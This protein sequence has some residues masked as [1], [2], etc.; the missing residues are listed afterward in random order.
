MC[1]WLSLLNDSIGLGMRGRKRRTHPD[2]VVR[3]CPPPGP[4]A[5]QASPAAS[6]AAGAAYTLSP[7]LIKNK[8]FML[9]STYTAPPFLLRYIL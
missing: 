7:P 9:P 6:H 2:R 5:S 1:T 8:N 3:V 4:P